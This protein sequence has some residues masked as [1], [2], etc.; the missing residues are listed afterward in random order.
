MNMIRPLLLTLALGLPFS[1]PADA[2]SPS[3]KETLA[4]YDQTTA[5]GYLTV[6]VHRY[7][8]PTFDSKGVR[9][10]PKALGT[11][12]ATVLFDRPDLFRFV[13]NPGQKNEFRAV[14][15]GE[16]L[17]WLDLSTGVFGKEKVDRLAEPLALALLGT[18]GELGRMGQTRDVVLGKGSKFTGAR[19]MPRVFGSR[20]AVATAWFHEGK[21]TGFDFEMRDGSRTFVAVLGFKPNVKTSPKDFEL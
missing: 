2:A 18:A 21:P 1:L 7:S 14:G 9:T 13:V 3:G 5:S 11:H 16:L 12:Q 17:R 4:L 19:V 8:A 10:G 6:Q 15:D 20:V